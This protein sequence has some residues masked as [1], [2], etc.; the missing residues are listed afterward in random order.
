[1]SDK[2]M[3]K[4]ALRRHA[5][6][7]MKVME[8]LDLNAL[9]TGLLKGHIR[10]AED[11]RPVKFMSQSV[12]TVVLSY[13]ALFVDKNG[14]N[15]IELWK[16]L[17]PMH[18]KLVEETWA[19]IQP[20]WNT[21]REFRDRAGFHADKPMKFFGARY[22]VAQDKRIDEALAEFVGLISFFL[23]AEN[24]GE[25]S[26]FE[27]ELDSLLNDLEVAQP[28]TYQREQFKAYLMLKKI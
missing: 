28:E 6:Y 13:F 21:I 18:K 12:R 16:E 4:D 25:L 3:R 19:R 8:F 2:Q 26:D 14:M 10:Y 20:T 24:R 1:V 23:K 27:T 5:V 22:R 9:R 7:R 17:F 11:L 15:V